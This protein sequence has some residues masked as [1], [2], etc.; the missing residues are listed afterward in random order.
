[1]TQAAV[2]LGPPW[3]KKQGRGVDANI[4]C[5][6]VH[7]KKYS[8][9]ELELLSVVWSVD[10][11]K[12]YLLGRE[13]T[14][15]TDLKALTSA[16]GENRANKTYQSRLTRCVD[17]LLTYQFKIV[18][19]PGKD[20]DIVDYLS[21]EPNADPWPVSE[22]DEKFVV[23]S[24]ENFYEALYCWNSRLSDTAES[25]D[26]VKILEISEEN[27][28]SNAKVNTSSHSCYSNQIGSNK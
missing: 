5:F 27:I 7:E 6:T 1:M 28:G 17:R 18:H 23:T 12:H 25:S 21:R 19:I 14:I 15:G 9:N 20:M 8:T 13:F 16:L 3:S 4:F 11:F 22:L 26:S 2:G 10:R 24:I